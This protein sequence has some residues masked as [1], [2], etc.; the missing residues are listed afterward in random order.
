[1]CIYC[2]LNIFFKNFLFIFGY[3]GSLLQG[4]GVLQLWQAESTFKLQ[5]VGLLLWL[6]LLGS[7][8]SGASRLQELWLTGSRLQAQYLWY[9][10]GLVALRHVGS[11]QTWDRTHDSCIGRQIL[12]HW[13]TRE[14]LYIYIYL[15]EVSW[16]IILC[17]F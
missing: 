16:F 7:T 6:L 13:T 17:Q 2:I 14:V 12:N 9:Y 3:A 5:G 8:G 15:I 1:M 11:S 4:V 10:S